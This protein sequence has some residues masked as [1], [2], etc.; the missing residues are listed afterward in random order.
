LRFAQCLELCRIGMQFE[1]GRDELF[2][3][4]SVPNFREIVNVEDL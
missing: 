3:R 1:L 2:H 4:T